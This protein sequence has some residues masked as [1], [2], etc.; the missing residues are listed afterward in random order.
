[1]YDCISSLTD[2]SGFTIECHGPNQVGCTRLEEDTIM[3]NYLSGEGNLCNLRRGHQAGSIGQERQCHVVLIVTLSRCRWSSSAECRQWHRLGA[4][5]TEGAGI[6]QRDV[7][8]QRGLPVPAGSSI[9]L[10]RREPL[11]DMGSDAAFVGS[12][13]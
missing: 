6:F 5:H 12:R 3:S 8:K 9:H 2:A 4:G 10:E 1:M 7:A 11:L 13:D